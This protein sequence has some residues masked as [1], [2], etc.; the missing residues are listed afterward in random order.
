L[1]TIGEPGPYYNPALTL[2]DSRLAVTRQDSGPGGGQIWLAD[3]ARGSLARFTLEA[4]AYDAPTWSRDGQHV[5]FSSNPE[6]DRWEIRRKPWD[7]SGG[8]EVVLEGK[9][10]LSAEDVSPDGRFL[11]YQTRGQDTLTDLMLLPLQGEKT[12]AELVRTPPFEYQAQ[13]SPDGRW[14]AYGAGV[15]GKWEVYVQP[16]PDTGARWQISAS[17][18]QPRWRPDG[19]ELFYLALDGKLMAVDIEATARGLTVGSPRALFSTLV[20]PGDNT[21]NSYVVARGGE[22]FLFANPVQQSGPPPVTIVL[23]WAAEHQKEP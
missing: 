12:P 17:G 5:Y 18:A 21:R 19:K 11:A 22:R 23:N 4:G 8:E 2:D 15:G 14:L 10:F 1:G 3:L 20:N 7:S 13:F 16:Y 9:S 6:S